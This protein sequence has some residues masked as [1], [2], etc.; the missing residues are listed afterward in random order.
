VGGEFRGKTGLAFNLGAFAN[1]FQAEV[2]AIIAAIRES[3]TMGYNSRTI[4]IF[5]D[6]QA[7]LKTLESVTVRSKLVLE[8]LECLSELVTHNSVQLV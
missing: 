2:F 6:S 4:T 8:C 7:A 5:T 1:V 3:I